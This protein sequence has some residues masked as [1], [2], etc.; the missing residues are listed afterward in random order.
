MQLMMTDIGLV[1][2]ILLKFVQYKCKPS[3][4]NPCGSN[5]CSH[6]NHG[7]KY[8]AACGSCRRERVAE[9]PRKLFTIIVT[10][11]FVQNLH[12]R[13]LFISITSLIHLVH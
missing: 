4:A 8:V 3:T 13:H 11:I 7:L 12:D 2:E 9:V 6:R 1:P 5:M 10:N